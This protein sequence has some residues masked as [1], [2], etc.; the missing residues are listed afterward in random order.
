MWTNSDK[1]YYLGARRVVDRLDAVV[2]RLSY[3]DKQGLFLTFVQDKFSLPTKLYGLDD[4]L[5]E[6]VTTIVK[7]TN[8]NIGVLLAGLKGAGKTITAKQ[9]C[10][11]L[12]FPVILITHAYPGIDDFLNDVKEN[13]LIFIDE[14][15]KVFKHDKNALLTVMDG[16]LDNGHRRIFLL[17]SNDIYVSP[18]LLERTG[19]IRYL[20]QYSDLTANLIHE[21]I[22]DTLIHLH[23]RDET[24]QFIST[25]ETITI[26]IVLSI[27]E[28]VN[29]FCKSP[30]EFKDIFNVKVNKDYCD[31][32][33]VIKSDPCRRN[34][35]AFKGERI[36]MYSSHH[37]QHTFKSVGKIMAVLDTNTIIV[38]DRETGKDRTFTQR[39]TIRLH[40]SFRDSPDANDA[41]NEDKREQEA[42]WDDDGGSD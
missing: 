37:I 11:T 25:L 29:I 17:T 41:D 28:E 18:N 38:K 9:L 40:K 22:D 3:N 15:E 5:I 31:I 4:T 16:A 14:Y 26:D 6:H 30:T 10:N 2:Y 20:R 19:R 35:L 23:L 8:K 33:E 42:H 13:M 39:P 21:I 36:T 1:N 32:Y 12:G 24:I 27:V 34:V 7:K